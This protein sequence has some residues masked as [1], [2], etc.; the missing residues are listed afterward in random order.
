MTYFRSFQ[1]VA[2]EYAEIKPVNER[3]V[4]NN[5]KPYGTSRNIRPIDN[6]SRKW[7]RIVKLSDTC[8]ALMCG[9][10]LGDTVYPAWR[11]K[12]VQTTPAITASYAPIVWHR[13]GEDDVVSVSNAFFRQPTAHH[14]FLRAWLPRG[15]TFVNKNGKHFLR[16]QHAWHETKDYSLRKATCDDKNVKANSFNLQFKVNEGGTFTPYKL[17]E[18]ATKVARKRVDIALKRRFKVRLEEFNQWVMAMGPLFPKDWKSRDEAQREANDYIQKVPSY[19]NHRVWRATDVPADI[20]RE[21]LIHPDHPL[22]MY[23]GREAW[24]AVAGTSWLKDERAIDRLRAFNNV[25]FGFE[26][27]VD[28]EM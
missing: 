1:H 25:V 9:H 17:P 20:A 18:I 26:K 28:V 3:D 19:P 14:Q 2:N 13:I 22:R 11:Y 15:M 5:Q 23:L 4:D 27:E 8:Y 7:E 10:T 12:D 16:V 24:L 6:R 21:V